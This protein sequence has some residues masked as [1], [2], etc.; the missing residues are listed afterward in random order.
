MSSI[1]WT[2][3]NSSAKLSILLLYKKTFVHQTFER[4]LYVIITLTAIYGIVFLAIFASHCHPVSHFWHPESPGSCRNIS[5]E[6][7]VSTSL[8]LVFDLVIIFLPMP[9][10]WRLRITVYKRI[11]LTMIFSIGLM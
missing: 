1:V 4:V 3:G 9:L 11:A 8:S 2:L 5:N 7:L 10:L 6:E